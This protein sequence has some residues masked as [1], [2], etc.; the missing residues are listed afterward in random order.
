MLVLANRQGTILSAAHTG[1][2]VR[3]FRTY[4]LIRALTW[5]VVVALYAVLT[6]LTPT[7]VHAQRQAGDIL[8]GGAVD[9]GSHLGTAT[10]G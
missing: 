2:V 9:L 8:I 5:A 7:L 4:T 1:G 6:H 3:K 10:Q